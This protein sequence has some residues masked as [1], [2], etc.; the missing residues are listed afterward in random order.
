MA[1]KIG[2]VE[3][4]SLSLQIPLRGFGRCWMHTAWL[5]FSLDFWIA[6]WVKRDVE[7][8][9]FPTCWDKAFLFCFVSHLATDNPYKCFSAIFTYFL[10]KQHF[11]EMQTKHVI[12]S[13]HLTSTATTP[14]ALVLFIWKMF[15]FLSGSQLFMLDNFVLAFSLSSPLYKP[16]CP[17]DGAT[18]RVK[19]LLCL[20]ETA[21][22]EQSS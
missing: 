20:P 11:L 2:N 16:S 15:P 19:T 7:K 9:Y 3:A 12:R 6:K 18:R 4:A 22:R 1:E 10:A 21:D 13:S 8:Q 17:W 14:V 5:T